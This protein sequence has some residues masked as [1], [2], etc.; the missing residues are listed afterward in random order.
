MHRRSKHLVTRRFTGR[1]IITLQIPLHLHNVHTLHPPHSLYTDDAH[2]STSASPPERWN[3]K[4]GIPW[5]F[6]MSAEAC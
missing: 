2:R 1:I 5:K 3:K 4:D 6:A